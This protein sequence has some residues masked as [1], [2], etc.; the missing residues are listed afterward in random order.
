MKKIKPI[1][2]LTAIEYGLKDGGTQFVSNYPGYHSYELFT[3]FNE[4]Q[5]SIDERV[6]FQRA[7]GSALSGKRSVLTLKGIGL[8]SACDEYFHSILYGVNAGLVIVVFDDTDVVSSPELFDSRYFYHSYGGLWFEPGSIQQA[9]DICR[10][11]FNI[12]EKY[13]IPVVIRLSSGYINLAEKKIIRK[14]KAKKFSN[15]AN[16]KLSNRE[17]NISPWSNRISDWKRKMKIINQAFSLHNHA[18]THKNEKDVQTVLVRVGAAEAKVNKKYDLELNIN[19]YPFPKLVLLEMINKNVHVDVVEEGSAFAQNMIDGLRQTT[20]KVEYKKHQATPKWLTYS[21]YEKL[22]TGLSSLEPKVVIGDE[23]SYTNETTKR[24]HF[25]FCYGASI[26]VTLG[27]AEAGIEYPWCVTGDAAF[28][29]GGYSAVVE[30]VNRGISMGIIII[31]NKIASA[32]GGQKIIEDEINLPKN[33]NV[34]NVDYTTTSEIEFTKIFETFTIT[35]GVSVL[36][37]GYKE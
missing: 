34:I 31:N 9:Y 29:H 21:T 10:E 5:I 28:L 6:A 36:V 1:D 17:K 23:G 24:I 8:A 35:K 11:A 27:I 37:V 18:E 14:Q 15:N 26:G 25:C 33:V 3:R 12:S 30:A 4:D 22:F 19:S 13:D 7:Y 16:N 32:T 20:T 2:S